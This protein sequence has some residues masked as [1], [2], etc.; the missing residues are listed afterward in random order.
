MVGRYIIGTLLHAHTYEAKMI[1][2]YDTY[3]YISDI[4]EC[5]DTPCMNGGECSDLVGRFEC[6]CVAG[7]EGTTCETGE[8][9]KRHSLCIVIWFP[10]LQCLTLER[11]NIIEA[12]E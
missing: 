10:K 11:D 2:L 7:Y 8:L 5:A 4:N 9:N 1:F 3:I 12:D 6:E